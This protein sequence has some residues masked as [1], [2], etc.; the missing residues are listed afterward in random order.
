MGEVIAVTVMKGGT[1]KTTSAVCMAQAAAFLG[2][3][4]LLVDLDS[5]GNASAALGGVLGGS[6]AA[7]LIDGRAPAADLIQ[8]TKQGI[9]LIPAEYKISGLQSYRGS[10][11][12]LQTALQPIRDRY[13]IVILDAANVPEI[14]LNTLQACTQL[15]IPLQADTFSLQA[16][17]MTYQAAKSIY[18]TNRE[19]Y[20]AG[21]IFTPA[22]SKTAFSDH[23]KEVITAEAAGLGV[24]V[25]GTVLTYA[26]EE[27]DENATI[28]ILERLRPIY[29]QYHRVIIPIDSLKKIV[30]LSN[31]YIFDRHNPDKS[32]DILD[33][34]ASMVSIQETAIEKEYRMLKQKLLDVQKKKNEFILDNNV[35]EA[36]DY[37]K[38]ESSLSS[39][40]NKMELTLKKD[41]KNITLEDI[42]KVIH[43]KTGIPIYEIVKD[44][45]ASICK[46]ESK[47]KDKIIGQDK[48][49][50]SL[51]SA[52]KKIKF[53]Y[54][55][56]KVKSYLFVGPTGVGKTNLAKI[57]AASQVGINNL[58]R[59]SVQLLQ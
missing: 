44:N 24:P 12:R 9:D 26:T 45:V 49:I 22:G 39:K 7:D 20:I 52:T 33:E 34:V 4:V 16:F 53:G 51:V 29:E 56:H 15:V 43:Q 11:R 35:E 46:L 23:I 14:M 31:Q 37:L 42:A 19:L 57:Y 18:Q 10:A 47:L 27:P 28:N 25:L 5:Q 13:D 38:E 8:H 6:G 3:S 59:V 54:S 30:E 32:I 55:N 58:I 48:A 40:V 21:I 17:R 50:D 41:R 36:Y 2:K 1:G